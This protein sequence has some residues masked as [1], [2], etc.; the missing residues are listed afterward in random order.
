MTL[1][2]FKYIHIA[3]VLFSVL[4][5]NGR[6]FY[7]L[8]YPY[9]TLPKYYSIMQRIMDTGLLLSGILLMILAK[10]I[11]FVNAQWLGVKLLLVIC[12]VLFGMR[13]MKAKARGKE[14]I[15]AYCL[16][17]LCIVTIVIL[18]KYHMVLWR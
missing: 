9:R 16:S 6:Y 7:R 2:V 15:L 1:M 5:L 18:S 13:A 3:L 14:S 12:Y 8:I 10:A 11:P 17:M 4:F